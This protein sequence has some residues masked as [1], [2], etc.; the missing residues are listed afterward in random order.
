MEKM[1]AAR[2]AQ[3]SSMK[4]DRAAKKIE[5]QLKKLPAAVV[6]TYPCSYGCGG[7]ISFKGRWGM[8]V[9]D[10]KP[11]WC[12]EYLEAKRLEADALKPRPPVPVKTTEE[13]IDEMIATRQWRPED[14]EEKLK[15]SHDVVMARWP[16]RNPAR[17]TA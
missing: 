14:I 17:R 13:L 2:R 5:R 12:R 15:V 3:V 11:H 8:N 7:E 6:R 9:S 1:W 10:G 4:I 16:R